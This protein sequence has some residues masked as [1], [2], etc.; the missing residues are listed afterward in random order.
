M[1]IE[2]L[3]TQIHQRPASQVIRDSDHKVLYLVFNVCF[4]SISLSLVE[5]PPTRAIAD[6]DG[7][8]FQQLGKQG[9][10]KEKK[11]KYVLIGKEL[12]VL[13]LSSG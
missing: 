12:E 3:N 7:I 10:S 6:T 8:L 13:W 4:N 2:N 11:E 5:V 9:K 1:D